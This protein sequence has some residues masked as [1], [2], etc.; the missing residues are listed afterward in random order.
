MPDAAR[1]SA[2]DLLRRFDGLKPKSGGG[3]IAKCTAHEDRQAS[4][5]IDIRG[6]K[7]L[8]R[9]FAGCE[10]SAV[11][12]AA[13]LTLADLFLEDKPAA[14][15]PAVRLVVPTVDTLAA[16]KGLPVEVLRRYGVRNVADLSEFERAKHGIKTS[17]GVWIPYFN[18]D[19]S[20]AA[21]TRVRTAHVAKDGSRWAGS[22]AAVVP[23][24]LHDLADA[25]EQGIVVVCEGESDYWS[26]RAMGAPALGMPGASTVNALKR[27]YLAE[28][29]KTIYVCQDADSAGQAFVSAVRELVTTWGLEVI[30]VRFPAG[31]KDANDFYKLAPATAADRFLALLGRA[32]VEDRPDPREFSTVG[33]IYRYTVPEHGIAFEL[34]QMRRSWGDLV[35]ELAVVREGV[36][37][38]FRGTCNVSNVERRQGVAQQIKRRA[39]LP[40]VDWSALV[41]DFAVRCLR[42]E[43]QGAASV[44]L[45]DVE[46]PAAMPML[47]VDG[48]VLDPSEPSCLFG[49]GGTGKSLLALYLA[50]TLANRGI[51]VA[52]IDGETNQ[53]VQRRRLA[54]LFGADLPRIEYVYMDRPLTYGVD[55]LTRII[56]EQGIQYAMLDSISFMCPEAE[57]AESVERFSAALRRL[58]IGTLAL[59]HITKAGEENQKKPFGSTMWHNRFR[60]TW[61][62]QRTDPDAAVTPIKAIGLWCRKYNDNEDERMPGPFGFEVARDA[63]GRV[64][65]R[66]V[67]LASVDGLAGKLPVWKQIEAA[68][69]SGPLTR[70]ELNEQIEAPSLNA[71]DKALANGRKKGRFMQL[72]AGDWCLVM[73]QTRE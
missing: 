30:P 51:R 70:V 58:Q 22:L 23:Y 18:P 55:R 28:P 68:L 33:E 29:V 59:A 4:L 62:I 31:C 1:Q 41:E 5:S 19:G 3:Y 27:E 40:D 13:G 24:G 64:R 6:G 56:R 72:P 67:D 63:S 66:R 14:R 12:A 53:V 37:D 25:S 42:A 7:M 15:A 44:N 17:E 10:A 54:A 35:G 38:V 60:V 16:A 47:S 65:Y 11:A 48:I 49:D 57:K 36:S 46:L 34:D 61:N 50:G 8:L 43:K 9:C 73:E 20:I 21:R 2:A 69:R 52:Y 26:L 45:A 71:V 39:A 32:A